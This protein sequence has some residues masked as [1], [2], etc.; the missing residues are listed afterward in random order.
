MINFAL[1]RKSTYYR[2]ICLATRRF[3]RSHY[4]RLAVMSVSTVRYHKYARIRAGF[5]LH[6][7]LSLFLSVSPTV[8]VCLSVSLSLFLSC[9]YAC[10]FFSL[11]IRYSRIIAGFN[12]YC[13]TSCIKSYSL[14]VLYVFHCIPLYNICT[15]M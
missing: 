11:N 9:E 2:I 8:S 13:D 6:E 3:L 12:L 15:V 4:F 7:S 1:H 14:L 10:Y 5:S